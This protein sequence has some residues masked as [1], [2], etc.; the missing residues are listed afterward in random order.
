MIKFQMKN[1]INYLQ[2]LP[3]TERQVVKRT[4]TACS[5]HHFAFL[6]SQIKLVNIRPEDIVDSNPEADSGINMDHFSPL[7][8]KM[9]LPKLIDQPIILV[10]IFHFQRS[11]PLYN[12]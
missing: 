10:A 3:V 11:T 8:G 4:T 2:L 6:D 9:H 1:G 12:I 7:P 5:V